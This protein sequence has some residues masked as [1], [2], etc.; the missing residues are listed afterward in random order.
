V[1]H[2][3]GVGALGPVFRTYEPSRDRLVAVKVFRLDI[4]PEQARSLADELSRTCEARLF[5][6]SIV[7]PVAAGLEG[8]VAYRAEEYVAA[9]SLDVAMRHYA[10]APLG[11]VV[12]FITQLA[13]AIDTA[14]S[15]GV[16]HGAL[17][18]RD[19]FVT[20]DEARA[21]GFGVVDA[22]DRVGLR[23]P[24]RRPYSPPERIAGEAWGVTADVFSLAAIT[25][26]LLTGRRPSGLGEQIGPLTGSPLGATA[27]RVREVLARAMDER[28]LHRYPTAM[29]FVS[30]LDRVGGQ[31]DT[32]DAAPAAEAPPPPVRSLNLVQGRSDRIEVRKPDPEPEA[33]PDLEPLEA[34]TP[35]EPVSLTVEDS[36]REVARRVIAAREVRRREN[37]AKA[38]PALDLSTFVPEK[39]TPEPEQPKPVVDID[40]SRVD[41]DLNIDEPV[42]E[43]PAVAAAPLPEPE[44]APAPERV[45]AVDEFRPREPEAPR[46]TERP[47]VSP[48]FAIEPFDPDLPPP[49]PQPM[50]KFPPPPPPSPVEEAPAERPRVVLLPLAV[51]LIVGLLVGY[52]AGYFVG[53]RDRDQDQL[54][55]ASPTSTLQ[56]PGTSGQAPT[57]P[58]DFSEQA[59]A[60]AQSSAPTPTSTPT[61]TPPTAAPAPAP[62][63]PRAVDPAVR[64]GR[65]VVSSTPS[66]AGVTVNGKWTGRTPLTLNDLPLGKYV[67]RIVE[68]GFEVARRE[69]SLSAADP[70][71][72]MSVELR[73]RNDKKA[74]APAP[75]PA[76]AATSGAVG[77]GEIYV[78]SR[79]RGARV[80]VDGKEYGVTPLRVP[81]QR[82][83]QH[84]VRLE[85]A[86]HAPFT[87]TKQV[88]AGAMARVTGSL[89]RIR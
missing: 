11:K 12:A 78:D 60:P 55:Q 89:E 54:A 62:S 20:P 77:S 70:T 73:S 50:R 49:I 19:V 32:R 16:G 82:V 57:A 24:V 26:E 36:P 83:G 39:A 85:L 87:E 37:K 1:L 80:F 44:P 5:H 45:V 28:P 51:M 46:P 18:P 71:Q 25:F 34:L 41:L 43:E 68:P 14:R 81:E 48:P 23:A 33:E 64:T 84:V 59:V 7:E 27:D 52:V 40:T 31:A 69:L 21:T 67:I 42:A 65:I 9:E 6:P 3:V 53:N 56:T 47:F 30:A 61:P 72:T 88:T 63:K 35:P 66:K 13:S 15:V 38:Q 8:T 29:D 17:H 4:T 10:P 86:D 79:P 76:P 22:L 74:P 58:K 75:A 2:Q